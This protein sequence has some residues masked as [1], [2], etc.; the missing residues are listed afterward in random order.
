MTDIKSRIISI[1][2]KFKAVSAVEHEN[3]YFWD[4]GHI[5]SFSLVEFIFL[6]ED[7]FDIKL[8][9]EDFTDPNFK[10]IDGLTEIVSSYKVE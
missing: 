2:N 3:Y 9:E 10:N 8:N 1:L 6:I 7:E 4:N 5:D